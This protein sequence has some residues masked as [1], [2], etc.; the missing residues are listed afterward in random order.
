[1]PTVLCGLVPLLAALATTPPDGP[2]SEVSSPEPRSRRVVIP[3]VTSD[4]R[5]EARLAPDSSTTFRF[6]SRLDPAAFTLEKRE[7]YFTLVEV[8]THAVTL[9]PGK[10]LPRDGLALTVGLLEGGFREQVTFTLLPATGEVDAQVRVVSAPLSVPV[11]QARLDI[12]RA[13]CEAGA[14]AHLVLSG[15]IGEEGVTTKTL[16]VPPAENELRAVHARV[17]RAEG[18][19]GV[20][21]KLALSSAATKPW[22]P[23]E[24]LLLDEKGE[25]VARPGVWLDGTRLAPGEQRTLALELDPLPGGAPRPLLLEIREKEGART[26][27]VQGLEFR[28]GKP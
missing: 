14:F 4:P 7:E 19:T 26:V 13:R 23:G 24:A 17:Y 28:G 22:R 20:E 15:R 3:E 1:L 5:P 10:A 8:G 21:V 18:L 25:V 27:R 11:L 12:M 6:E 9:E 16:P 2:S